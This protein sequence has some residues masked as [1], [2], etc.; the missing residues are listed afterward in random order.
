MKKHPS[1]KITVKIFWISFVIS[2]TSLF[3][4]MFCN[5]WG[6]ASFVTT[7]IKIIFT[8]FMILLLCSES[9]LVLYYANKNNFS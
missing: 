8:I 7:A 2:T 1:E 4:L 5:F 3:F 9:I 6:F